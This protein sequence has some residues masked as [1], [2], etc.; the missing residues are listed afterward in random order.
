MDVVSIG[1]YR[2]G[3]NLVVVTHMDLLITE[4]LVNPLLAIPLGNS[5]FVEVINVEEVEVHIN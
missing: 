4:A 2:M 3:F 5:A 1:C